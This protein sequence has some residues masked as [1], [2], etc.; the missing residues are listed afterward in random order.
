MQSSLIEKS[1]GSHL[2]NGCGS[3]TGKNEKKP[4][5]KPI[6][7]DLKIDLRNHVEDKVQI[8]SQK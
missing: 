7:L 1:K 4:S 5:E 3:E 2:W 6:T 8:I